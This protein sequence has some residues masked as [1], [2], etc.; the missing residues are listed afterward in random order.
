M[1]GTRDAELE[2]LIAEYETQLL[3]FA[4]RIVNDA[5]AARDV[6]QQAAA[7]GVAESI[8]IDMPP[9]GRVLTFHRAVQIDWGSDLNIAFKS[10]AT[11]TAQWQGQ[12]WPTL[13]L[14]M[15]LS[16]VLRRRR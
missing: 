8:K 2:A 16:L 6:V 14:F 1:S 5:D 3:R 15:G 7:T 10:R 11:H 4:T 9:S 12:V 13:I